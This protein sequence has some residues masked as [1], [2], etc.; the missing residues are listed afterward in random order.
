[1]MLGVT[2]K[3]SRT[4]SARRMRPMHAEGVVAL[5]RIG[6]RLG[7]YRRV[8]AARPRVA[9][10]DLGADV[11]AGVCPAVDQD[12]LDA[13]GEITNMILGQRENDLRRDAWAN[14]TQHS[15]GHL[16]PQLYHT[17]RRSQRVERCPL[18]SRWRHHRDTDFAWRS[19][20]KSRPAPASR[21]TSRLWSPIE[22]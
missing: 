2:L 13:V 3:D 4:D 14:G 5:G 18:R 21:I 10:K 8:S 17:Q 19:A 9:K 16:W 6:G 7:W 15:N 11:D 20:W 12:V 22:A 1:M